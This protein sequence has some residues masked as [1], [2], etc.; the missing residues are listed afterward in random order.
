MLG[1]I[2]LARPVDEPVLETAI[3]ICA[4]ADQF[5]EQGITRADAVSGVRPDPY[6]AGRRDTA[7]AWKQKVALA[8]D[9]ALHHDLLETAS[10]Q[11]LGA[12]YV[13]GPATVEQARI[14]HAAEVMGEEE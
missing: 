6:T 4:F 2:I 13:R 7:K 1:E 3:R 14:A 5:M 8:I 10:G 11:R 9:L 12:R